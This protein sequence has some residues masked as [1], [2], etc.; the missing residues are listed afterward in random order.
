MPYRLSAIDSFFGALA[1]ATA[2]CHVI[3]MWE[4]VD[5]EVAFQ[6]PSG[7]RYPI[8]TPEHVCRN[9]V[10]TLLLGDEIVSHTSSVVSS[11]D[12]MIVQQDCRLT[13]AA[14]EEGQ[15]TC[16][17][18]TPL[19]AANT[20]QIIYGR[21]KLANRRLKPSNASSLPAGAIMFG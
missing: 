19:G 16:P 7:L 3:A 15:S 6:P 11:I 14:S 18:L 20:R 12:C 9:G 2:I 17:I 8:S 1:R 13:T 5:H 4:Q 21:S 10:L